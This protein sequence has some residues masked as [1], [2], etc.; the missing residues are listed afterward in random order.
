[1]VTWHGFSTK[2]NATN[3]VLVLFGALRPGQ[4]IRSAGAG[5]HLV[6]EVVVPSHGLRNDTYA[7]CEFAEHDGVRQLVSIQFQARAGR[8]LLKADLSTFRWRRLKMSLI[9]V[10]EPSSQLRL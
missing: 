2:L 10:A 4:R 3:C 7:I 8:A 1:M 9:G 6:V 5:S